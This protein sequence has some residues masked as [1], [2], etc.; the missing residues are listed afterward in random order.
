[1]QLDIAEGVTLKEL[2]NSLPFDL[3]GW[4]SL[5]AATVYMGVAFAPYAHGGLLTAW[6]AVLGTGLAGWGLSM[7]QRRSMPMSDLDF[8]RRWH[9]FSMAGAVQMNVLIGLS[10][11]L[12]LP[13]APPQLVDAQIVFYCWY[14]LTFALVANEGVDR[15]RWT[16]WLVSGSLAAY[17]LIYPPHGGRIVGL[18]VIAM[19]LTAAL[20]Q[21]LIRRSV[22]RATI[23]QIKAETAKSELALALGQVSAQ[24]DARA[25]F[26]ASVS[27]DL[28]QPLQAAQMLFELACDPADSSSPA[29]ARDG[30]AAFASMRGLIEQMLEFMRLSAQRPS[31]ATRQLMTV[32]EAL[33]PVR[34]RY[35]WRECG[36]VSLRWLPCSARI[37]VN[38]EQLHRVIGN[39]IDNALHHAQA[40]RI[41]I[42]ARR[43]AGTIELWII[44]D[45]VGIPDELLP[46]LFEP[47][48]RGTRPERAETGF[49][50]GLASAKLLAEASGGT[51]S[52]GQSK[53]RGT[54]FKL[55]LPRHKRE[56]ALPVDVPAPCYAV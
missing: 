44:D 10:V 56:P 34:A 14:I 35:R 51:L 41:V 12:L 21:R 33:E 50:L 7:L 52:L 27:H 48:V 24:R 47:Y 53:A 37:S 2:R 32:D 5:V 23:Q 25:R 42:G 4:L 45:G 46:T 17:L 39:L 15:V 13:A 28:Q 20:L 18:V 11:W 3:V 40:D 16:L 9:G 26:M 6:L 30:R 31:A 49:G 8:L 54:W 55:I 29:I 22:V 38:P 43:R 36:T 1:M 19:G